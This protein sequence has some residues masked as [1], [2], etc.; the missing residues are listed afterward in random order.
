MPFIRYRTGD[1]AVF[2]EAKKGCGAALMTIKD[3]KSRIGSMRNC[4]MART[5]T[6]P[7]S[8]TQFSIFPNN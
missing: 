5:S 2:G 6:P 4:R 7:S 8:T 3:V 1:L